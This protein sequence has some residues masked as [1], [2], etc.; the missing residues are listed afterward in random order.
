[1]G[2]AV[3]SRRFTSG[4][5]TLIEM[6]VVLAIVS[7]VA[8]LV[9]PL[10]PDTEGTKLRVAARDTAS[11]LRY[12]QDEASTRK[13]QYRLRVLFQENALMVEQVLP[14][15]DTVVPKDEY[16]RMRELPEGVTIADTIT[17]R[18]GKL[19]LGEATIDCGP[20]GLSGFLQIHLAGKKG[21]TF[22]ISAYPGSGKVT[23]R[24]GY[25]EEER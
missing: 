9:F 15:G 3:S 11:L 13:T 22:T 16:L 6:M 24:E 4:G 19:S 14:D 12:L 20:G 25:F 23:V 7:M 1:M 21:S 18:R 5:F 10:L 2:V 17:S 8:L